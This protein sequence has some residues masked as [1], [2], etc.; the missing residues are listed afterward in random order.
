MG[1]TTLKDKILEQ[2]KDLPEEQ[3]N[4]L[5]ER[6]ENMSSDEFEKFLQNYAVPLQECLFC[7]II[8]GKIATIK[9]YESKNI[10][11]VLDVNPVTRGHILVMPKQHYQFLTQLPDSLLFEIFNFVKHIIPA[12]IRTVKSQGVTISI[13]QGKEQT[14]PHFIVNIIPRFKDDKLDFSLKRLKLQKDELENVAASIRAEASQIAKQAIGKGRVGKKADEEEVGEVEEEEQAE[15]IAEKAGENEEQETE[16]REEGIKSSSG[17]S[18]EQLAKF[19][20][21]RIPS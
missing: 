11:A 1:E 5:R 4:E 14:I 8:Q 21:G 9:I 7:Q 12:I 20:R 17:F 6:I 3:A 2:L 18:D 19:F 15:E 13:L 10:L 16:E